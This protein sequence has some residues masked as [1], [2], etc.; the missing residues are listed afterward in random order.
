[1]LLDVLQSASGSAVVTHIW[2]SGDLIVFM[3]NASELM[4][5][6]EGND[7]G[8]C[9][10][11]EDCLYT[12]NIGAYQGHGTLEYRETIPAGTTVH[13]VDVYTYDTNGY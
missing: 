7:N 12:P 4:F 1:V 3:R 8:L 9:E 11:Y 6:G 2:D 5:D 13:H 10:S